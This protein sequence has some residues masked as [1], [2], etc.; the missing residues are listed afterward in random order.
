MYEVLGL[1]MAG[2]ITGAMAKP[3]IARGGRKLFGSADER[4]LARV[5]GQALVLALRQHCGDMSERELGELA[6]KVEETFSDERFKEMPE[7]IQVDVSSIPVLLRGVF[8]SRLQPLYATRNDGVTDAAS[9][10]ITATLDD[11]VDD[12]LNAVSTLAA[13]EPHDAHL[14]HA[15]R[16]EWLLQR[17][18]SP[19]NGRIEVRY[20]LC[21]SLS[22]LAEIAD[23]DLS[24]LPAERP[25]LLDNE[26][27]ALWRDCSLVVE[28][29]DD[30]PRFASAAWGSREEYQAAYPEARPPSSAEG[31]PYF[32]LTRPCDDSD[33]AKLSSLSKLAKGLLESGMPPAEVAVVGA[34]LAHKCGSGE[35]EFEEE[36]LIRNVW[37]LFAEV[38][39]DGGVAVRLQS[40]H[41]KRRDGGMTKW[42]DRTSDAIDESLPLSDIPLLSG[43]SLVIPVATFVPKEAMSEPATTTVDYTAMY[44][45]GQDQRTGIADLRQHP[46]LAEMWGPAFLPESLRYSTMGESLE[47]SIRQFDLSKTLV[48]SRH[49]AMGSCPH[50]FAQSNDGA[51]RYLASAFTELGSGTVQEFAV[52]VPAGCK[53]LIVA[54]LE[55]EETTLISVEIDRQTVMSGVVLRCGEEVVIEAKDGSSVLLRGF[56][57]ELGPVVA[58]SDVL[59]NGLIRDYVQRS[60]C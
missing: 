55:F 50:V 2:T 30:D 39:I 53:R 20:H 51:L 5:S 23:F 8:R 32:E 56:Y 31:L 16:D 42:S 9:I 45:I 37:G 4:A 1:K 44:E 26:V 24:L 29:P 10:G 7:A 14:L 40:L 58:G 36:F 59:R 46:A 57:E 6:E 52:T 49:W 41:G 19:A 38:V 21:T 48:Q 60:M 33:I 25:R 22:I 43:E 13:F 18:T 34:R 47:A 12:I 15:F 54:E 27:S 11:L 35:P 3:V 28:I 17:S